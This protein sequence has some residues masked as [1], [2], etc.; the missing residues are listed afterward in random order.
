MSCNPNHLLIEL[1][2]S[3]RKLGHFVMGKEG[4]MTT[5]FGLAFDLEAAKYEVDRL[6]AT[7]AKLIEALEP[8]AR[9]AEDSPPTSPDS[10]TLY[11]GAFV[12]IRLGD[13]RR[14]RAAIEEAR[15]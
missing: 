2:V 15:K 4:T 13:A 3:R 12:G 5:G 8:L 14:A 1:G 10:R 7:N 6:R 9:C 11:D